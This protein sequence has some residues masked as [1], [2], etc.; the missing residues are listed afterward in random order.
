MKNHK[1]FRIY[2]EDKSLF[3]RVR[4]FESKEKMYEHFDGVKENYP[5]QEKNFEAICL[6]HKIEKK[7]PSSG[8][9][10]TPEVGEI[11]FYEDCIGGGIVSHEATHATMYYLER[12]GLEDYSRLGAYGD[13]HEPMCWLQGKIVA[14]FW[15]RW[16]DIKG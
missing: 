8:W 3:F 16:Y 1:K 14:E 9:R 4:V 7:Y 12:N 15:S 5:G 2:P 11:W 10:L 6:N 13:M